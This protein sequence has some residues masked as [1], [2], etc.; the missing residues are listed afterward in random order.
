MNIC[1]ANGNYAASQMPQNGINQCEDAVSRTLQKQIA[2][3]QKQMQELSS[4][5]EMEMEEKMQ[6]RQEIQKQIQD[7]K[8]QLRQHQAELRKEKQEKKVKEPEN[9]KQEKCYEQE[10]V[11]VIL[12]ADAAVK[13]TEL[14]SNVV[15]KLEGRADILQTEI[16]LEKERAVNGLSANTEA[17]EKELAEIEKRKIFDRR[18]DN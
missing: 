16:R 2:D 7:L 3:A 13:Q 8:N 9:V 14:Q 4:N 10:G 6:R 15:Q 17:K 5:K 1:I 12:S 11:E 18:N